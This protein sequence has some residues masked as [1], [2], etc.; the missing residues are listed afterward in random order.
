M[1]MLLRKDK[2][3]SS[4]EKT[5][6]QVDGQL[7]LFNEAELEADASVPEPIKKTVNGYVRTGS[8]K[9]REELIKDL[10]ARE[11]LCETDPNEL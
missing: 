1:V 2:F 9:N 8:R 11:I 7:S 3:G 5:P 4:S 6:K 10:P